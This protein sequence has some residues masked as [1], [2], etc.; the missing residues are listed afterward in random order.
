MTFP[1]ISP[2]FC[3]YSYSIRQ[4]HRMVPASTRKYLWAS[5]RAVTRYEESV[6]RHTWKRRC[7]VWT[8]VVG[9]PPFLRRTVTKL[10][11]R[12][13]GAVA[14]DQRLHP[15]GH[16]RALWQTQVSRH[17]DTREIADAEQS[18][19]ICQ[20]RV[21][22]CKSHR[23]LTLTW[24]LQ[25]SW[26]L[27]NSVRLLLLHPST[28]LPTPFASSVDISLTQTANFQCRCKFDSSR[29]ESC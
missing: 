9:G 10:H 21:V 27:E 16:R 23:C 15:S 3:S 17:N 28:L 24:M 14:F 22:E 11:H 18:T 25:Y 13:R 19:R 26:L 2:S 1:L 4:R 6:T 8:A 29:F 7:C 20:V 12:E 5:P